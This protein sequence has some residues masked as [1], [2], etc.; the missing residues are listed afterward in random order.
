MG[1]LFFFRSASGRQIL[2]SPPPEPGPHEARRANH[3]SVPSQA[4]KI[5]AA[6][7]AATASRPLIASCLVLFPCLALSLSLPLPLACHACLRLSRQLRPVLTLQPPRSTTAKDDIPPYESLARDPIRYDTP[8][9]D[10][11][12]SSSSHSLNTGWCGLRPI[13]HALNHHPSRACMASVG[14]YASLA[15]SLARSVHQTSAL[16][17]LDLLD[18]QCLPRNL[19]SSTAASSSHLQSRHLRR[20]CRET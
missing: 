19:F 8:R 17:R 1:P 12:R 16:A 3:P 6:A 4:C 9:F 13:V 10:P 7:A 20:V 14:K 5:R 11:I 18:L 15:R 2:S